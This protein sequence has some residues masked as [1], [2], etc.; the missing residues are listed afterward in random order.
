MTVNIQQLATLT[1]I[2]RPERAVYWDGKDNTGQPV[3][4]G[5]YFYQ[6]SVSS[7]ARSRSIGTG[8]FSQTR[9]MLLVK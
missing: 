5:V 2:V 3:A 7:E 9:R 4:S 6:L 8:D 1:L